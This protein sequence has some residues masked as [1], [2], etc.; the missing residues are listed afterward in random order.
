MDIKSVEKIY[1]KV[2]AVKKLDQ[3]IIEIDRLA[4]L[5]ANGNVGVNLSL[6]I[7]D[8]DKAAKLEAENGSKVNKG[9]I[10]GLQFTTLYWT[11]GGSEPKP[12]KNE[13]I[14][15]YKQIV[16][17]EV[18]LQIL[19]TLLGDKVTKRAEL[20]RQLQELGLKIA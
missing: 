12:P 18:T 17:P 6:A 9:L 7:E 10:G 13:A 14:T 19:G 4:L 8:F 15:E 5:I 3:E 20:I 2:A 16:S 11:F 1:N